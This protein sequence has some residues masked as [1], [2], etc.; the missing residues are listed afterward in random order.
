[1]HCLNEVTLAGALSLVRFMLFITTDCF[2]SSHFIIP[3]CLNCEIE[4]K[5]RSL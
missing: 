1:M 4:G 5:N 2:A 3:M